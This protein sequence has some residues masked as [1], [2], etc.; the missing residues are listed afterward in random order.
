[1]HKKKTE[2]ALVSKLEECIHCQVPR[3]K[4]H[5]LAKNQRDGGKK[6]TRGLFSSNVYLFI[7]ELDLKDVEKERWCLQAKLD[8]EI[9]KMEIFKQMS[10]TWTPI[11]A[12]DSKHSNK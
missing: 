9:R 6:Q 7:S 2:I 10:W 12:A 11:I 1:M 3:C 5:L 8:Y 4:R